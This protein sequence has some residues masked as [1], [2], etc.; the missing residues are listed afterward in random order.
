MAIY[1]DERSKTFYLESRDLS[2]VFRIN[3]HGFLQHLYYGRRI[4]REDVGFSVALPDRGHGCCLPGS[5]RRQSMDEYRNECPI[6]GRSDFRESMVD[7]TF[8]NGVVGD[9]VYDGH[10]LYARP[11]ALHRSGGAGHGTCLDERR[12][13]NAGSQA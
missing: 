9:F 2:Y 1:F 5:D 7:F 6:F 4:P 8:P 12:R 11:A 10:K 13:R 3:E